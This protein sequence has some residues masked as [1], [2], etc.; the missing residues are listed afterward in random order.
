MK[1]NGLRLRCGRFCQAG[2][3]EEVVR[4]FSSQAEHMC[5]D[6]EAW[7]ERGRLVIGKIGKFERQE[8]DRERWL[9]SKYRLL[10]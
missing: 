8:Y 4:M 6:L 1:K 5:R 9:V 7:I 10:Q 2:Q 3:T